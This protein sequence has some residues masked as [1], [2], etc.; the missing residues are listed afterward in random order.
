[1]APPIEVPGRRAGIQAGFCPAMLAAVHQYVDQHVA[2]R[3]RGGERPGMI[4]IPP[5]G[6]PPIERAV[7]RPRHA[8]GQAPEAAAERQRIIRLD[9]QMQVI[10]LDAEVQEAEVTVGHRS[11]GAADGRED[12][13]GPQ[14]A[15][16]RPRTERDVHGVRADVRGPRTMRDTRAA[17]WGGLPSGPRPTA[18]PGPGGREG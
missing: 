3:S 17:A 12:S 14:A 7:H 5:D 1:M 16:G 13:A 15:D 18:T 4:S 2:H 10:V 9:D 8:D 6:T 11:E